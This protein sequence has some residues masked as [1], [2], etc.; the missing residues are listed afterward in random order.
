M[1]REHLI[2]NLVKE[3]KEKNIIDNNKINNYVLKSNLVKTKLDQIVFLNEY[4][5]IIP[6]PNLYVCSEFLKC[7]SL[8]KEYVDFLVLC[9]MKNI[10]ILD[11]NTITSIYENNPELVEYIYNELSHNS[12]DDVA[13]F[14][15]LILGGMGIKDPLKFFDLFLKNNNFVNPELVLISAIQYVTNPHKIPK[16]IIKMLINYSDSENTP[17]KYSAIHVLVNQFN[18]NPE[19]CKKLI[20]LAKTD[21]DTKLVI[22]HSLIKIAKK[23]PDFCLQ[24]LQECAKT[25]NIALILNNI[26]WGLGSISKNYPIECLTIIKNWI[27]KFDLSIQCGSITWSAE[28]I[29]ESKCFEKIEEFLL[30]WIDIESRSRAEN[31][32][33]ILEF[34]LPRLTYDIYKKNVSYLLSLLEKI[35]YKQKRKSSFIVRTIE[36]VFSETY[37]NLNNSSHTLNSIPFNN[38][39]REL[40]K[41]IAI[42]Q[43]VDTTLV[44][45][46]KCPT[47]QILAL[48]NNILQHKKSIDLVQ[49][50]QNLE[51][52]PNIIAFLDKNKLYKLIDTQKNHPLVLLLSE[53]KITKQF[54]KNIAKKIGKTN[55][56]SYKKRLMEFISRKSRAILDDL[57]TSLKDLDE[58]RTK[59]LK[60]Q[61]LYN[62]FYPGLIQLNIYT[63]LKKKY[64]TELEPEVYPK[65]L[66]IKLNIDNQNYFFEIYTPEN[67]MRLKYVKTPHTIDPDRFLCKTIKKIQGQIKACKS[68]NSPVIL[69]IDNQCMSVDEF[70]IRDFLEGS[71]H[72]QIPFDELNTTPKPSTIRTNNSINEV[73]ADGNL[74][75][76][77]ILLRREIDDI[78][79]KVKL[80]GQ[81]YEN[82]KAKFPIDK[83]IFKK[84]ENSL[85][86]IGV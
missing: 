51:P 18:E 30:E 80:Y 8:T 72:F 81:T 27:K 26:A 25:D 79:L 12:N 65:K 33:R 9:V 47:M 42:Y 54:I 36:I 22:A 78:D 84:I 76:A 73:I 40:L 39:C 41:K 2:K 20:H 46:L 60:E 62:G 3:I 10:D 86:D 17:I 57:D 5:E 24:L 32:R 66:D 11:R 44:H 77:V 23:N 74:L 70:D 21:A 35:D 1:K 53:S 63:R 16:K 43:N 29:A 85:F 19:I 6:Y 61:L 34:S 71:L 69:I 56:E 49:T 52:F 13:Y 7:A 59:K 14:L 82:P 31:T 64:D 83:K 37:H 55:D 15:G 50:K 58:K 48:V 68:L 67:L 4:V 28:Q 38:S 75:S 45:D